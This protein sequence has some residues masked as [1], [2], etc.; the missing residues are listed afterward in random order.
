MLAGL[1]FIR[2]RTKYIRYKIFRKAAV[3]SFLFDLG[4]ESFSDA[5]LLVYTSVRIVQLFLCSGTRLYYKAVLLRC[6]RAE[7]IPI[8]RK[9]SR[10]AVSQNFT[11]RSSIFSLYSVEIS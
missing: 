10:V 2:A 4:F 8:A 7:K 11:I 1:E 9:C 6:L 3:Y 5:I